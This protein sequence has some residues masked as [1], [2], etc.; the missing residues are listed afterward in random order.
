[1]VEKHGIVASAGSFEVK[2]YEI[3]AKI[4]FQIG[5]RYTPTRKP[6]GADPSKWLTNRAPDQHHVARVSFGRGIDCLIWECEF[7]VGDEGT[8]VV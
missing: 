2:K 6:S 1:M 4:S 5:T 3:N 8:K 7:R